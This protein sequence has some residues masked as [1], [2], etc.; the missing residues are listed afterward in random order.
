MATK[1]ALLATIHNHLQNKPIGNY[2][3]Y[4]LKFVYWAI[5]DVQTIRE[6]H[7]LPKEN[8]HL[9]QGRVRSSEVLSEEIKSQLEEQ[10]NMELAENYTTLLKSMGKTGT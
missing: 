10:R 6:G 7:I 2:L 8:K 1:C 4:I 3:F 9:I 5:D